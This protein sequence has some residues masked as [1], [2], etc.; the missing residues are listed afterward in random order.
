M[1]VEDHPKYKEWREAHDRLT[2]AQERYDEAVAN[3]HPQTEIN[4][5]ER[6]LNRAQASY[7]LIARE[8]D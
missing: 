3:K 7:D 5:A 6:E 1:P 2:T 4:L 8:I